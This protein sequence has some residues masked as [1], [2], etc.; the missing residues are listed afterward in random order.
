[1]TRNLLGA[2]ALVVSLALPARAQTLPSEPIVFANGRVTLGGEVSW[3][4]APEDPGFFNYTDYQ[5]SVL[6]LLRL[7]LTASVTA[8]H[9]L[10]FLGELR[11]DNGRHPQPYAFYARIRP[12]SDRAF[13]IQIG[14]VPPTFGAFSRRTYPADNP[15]IGYP[16]GYQYLTSIR[17]DSLPASADELLRMRG[18][19]WLS[20]FSIGNPVADRG[21]P[22][23]SAFRWDSG[24]QLHAAN[25]LVDATASLTAGTLA[26]PLLGD[27]N[28]GRQAAGRVALHPIAGLVVG[29]SVAR[30]P[31]VSQAAA[32]AAVGEGRDGEFTQTA[33]GGDVE[34]SRDYYLVRLETIVSDWTL[35]RVGAPGGDLTLRAV[36]TSVEGRYKIRPGLYAAARLDHLG[37]SEVTGATRSDTWDAPVTR[38]E[39][40]AG[41]S[42]Q[43]NLLVKVEYQHNARS[44]GR[45][46]QLHLGA[47][48]LVFWF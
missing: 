6:R 35:P 32:R 12:W 36:A 5:D 24:V 43:R 41:Y 22:L 2:C 3:S 13:D 38:V 15:L 17:P 46:Q 8:G 27:D 29:G 19:G 47:A 37:F 39:L 20:S 44:G 28:S 7:G 26:N 40:G 33:W 31:F 11:S 1:M 9:H 10:T 21:V 34:Y 14:R 23:A 16:L 25:D 4:F 30:G 48:Q 45:V 42:I 18:R